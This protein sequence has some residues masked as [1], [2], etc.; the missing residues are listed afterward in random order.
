[1][2]NIV[3]LLG[4]LILTSCERNE[5]GP[6]IQPS[7]RTVF[8]DNGLFILNE[9]NFGTGN[10]SISFYSCDSGKIYN[11]IFY[12]ANRRTPG[13]IPFSMTM[14][15]DTGY[16]VVN[17]SG[18]IEVVNGGTMAVYK[19]ITGLTSPRYLLPVGGNKGY[20]SDLYSDSIAVIDMNNL[21][22]NG[23]IDIGRSSESMVKSGNK[24]YVASWSGDNR[25]TIIDIA[26]NEVE[27]SIDV[28]R[29]PQSMVI[30]KRGVL[31]VLCSGGFMQEELPALISINTTNDEIAG[32][33]LF[34]AG[35]YPT[36]LGINYS[37]DTLYYIDNGVFRLSI[38]DITLP[39][40]PFIYAGERLFYR[41][42]ASIQNGNIFVTDAVD[43]QKK[44]RLLRYSLSGALLEVLETG[45]IPGTMVY[46][47][48]KNNRR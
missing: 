25:L 47:S 24:V 21:R 44:G 36:S 6:V 46:R 8:E 20:I 33:L 19:T 16:I 23:F 22:I 28:T 3:I 35:S 40:S 7:G 42:E 31:W 43:Y 38:D 13:D 15:G 26:S 1:M 41:I 29:E 27:G 37:G 18:K 11:N 14:Q 48:A 39:V 45:I 17:N 32:S 34:P 2:R 4:F 12:A 9:G 30:D 5:P 10:G